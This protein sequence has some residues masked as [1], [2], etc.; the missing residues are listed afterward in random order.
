MK[1]EPRERFWQDVALVLVAMFALA[2]I[3]TT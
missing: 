1:T 2:V 3:L